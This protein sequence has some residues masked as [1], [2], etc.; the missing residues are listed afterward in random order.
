MQ[1][2]RSILIVGGGTAGWLTAAYLAKALRV[3]EQ[4]HLEITLL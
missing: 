1:R 2:R 3:A 4:S